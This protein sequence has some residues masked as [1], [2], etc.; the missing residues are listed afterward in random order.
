MQDLEDRKLLLLKQKK[1][2]LKLM[3]GAAMAIVQHPDNPELIKSQ[4]EA[5]LIC[6]RRDDDISAQ[7]AELD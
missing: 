3:E 1:D 2:M 5:F 4:T 7:L 6:K